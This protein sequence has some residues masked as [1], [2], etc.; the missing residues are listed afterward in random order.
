MRDFPDWKFC[1]FYDGFISHLH[2][3]ALQIFADHNILCV[4]EEGDTSDTCQAYDDQVAKA[5]KRLIREAIDK[6]RRVVN[7][8][9]QWI[10][11]GITIEAISKVDPK[12]WENSFVKVNLHPDHRVPFVDWLKRIDSKIETGERFFTKHNSSLYNAMPALWKNMKIE[13]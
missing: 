1:L 4:K 6:T 3:D 11:I 12:V 8:L 9:N 10:L 2:T 5:D 7:I 13:V